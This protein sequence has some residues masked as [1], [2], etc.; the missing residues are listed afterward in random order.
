MH[1]FKDSDLILNQ[2]SSIYHLQLQPEMIADTIFLVGDPGRVTSIS[3]HFDHIFYK[4]A[5]REFICHS[6]EIGN[7][8]L[9]VIST[10]IGTDNIDIVVNELDILVNYN[11]ISRT[12]REIKKKLNFIRIGTSGTIQPEI[13]PFNVVASAYGLGLDGMMHFYETNNYLMQ[14][15][16]ME[17]VKSNAPDL[18]SVCNPYIFEGDA[19]LL[20]KFGAEYIKGITATSPG[21]YGPQARF[22]RYKQKAKNLLETMG[23]F[24]F[25]NQ[26]IINIEMETAGIY[27][28]SNMLGHNALSINL[29]LANRLNGKFEPDY[30]LKMNN[31]IKSVLEK[32]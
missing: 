19:D 6:G 5:N 16:F 12:E 4:T 31:L 18:L 29:I 22:L 2:D 8:S 1:I 28:L 14:A 27:G 10:G 23:T 9:T 26:K 24:R 32:I 15:N 25:N 3:E 30:K 7:K 13:E 11:L 21:F 17:E 20:Q